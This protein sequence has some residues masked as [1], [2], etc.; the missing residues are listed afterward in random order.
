MREFLEDAE[1]HRGDAY[2][3]AQKLTQQELPRRFYKEAG[4]L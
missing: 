2:R 4:V 3:L 1:S